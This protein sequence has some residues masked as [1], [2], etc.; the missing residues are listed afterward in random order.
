M[1]GATA[2]VA[3]FVGL[4]NVLESFI[5]EK[6]RDV[7]DCVL[8]MQFAIAC[9]IGVP[10]I[11]PDRLN[12]AQTQISYVLLGPIIVPFISSD[13]PSTTQISYIMYT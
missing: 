10:S 13:N 3:E 8:S 11:R 7:F 6:D 12:P 4:S 2:A 9:E 5:E 1:E